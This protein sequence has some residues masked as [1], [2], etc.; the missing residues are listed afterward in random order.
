MGFTA[1]NATPRSKIFPSLLPHPEFWRNYIMYN[2]EVKEM[3]YPSGWKLKFSLVK[4]NNV[5][6]YLV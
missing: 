6:N 1:T 3:I 2:M 4:Q 5:W